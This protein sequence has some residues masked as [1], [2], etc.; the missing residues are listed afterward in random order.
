MAQDNEEVLQSR[1]AAAV[2]S[3]GISSDAI[4]AAILRIIIGRELRGKVLDYGAGVGRL[5]RRLLSLKRFEQIWA[6]DILSV[7]PD[8]ADKVEWIE[9]DL[10]SPIANHDEFFDVA[11][12]AEVIEHLENPRAT[13]RD[14]YRVL[15]PGGTVII[16][17]PNN[18]SWRAILA[19]L[20]RG[21]Y[22]AFGDTSYP[23]H[24]VALLRKDF[25]RIFHEAKFGS[26]VFCYTDEGG[27]PGKPKITWQA[28]TFGFLRGIRFSDNVV[29][30]ATKPR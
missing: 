5:T 22:V 18:E 20:L 30:V 8:L 13:V 24:I 28:I 7:S 27:F 3:G 21:H 19:F 25:E 23:A 17:S 15:R 6:A 29:V 16:T 11:L 26:P 10:N 12:A 1:R 4:Y 2:F 14:L 9:Q